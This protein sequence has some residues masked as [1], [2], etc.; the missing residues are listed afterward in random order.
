M[1]GKSCVHCVVLS[2]RGWSIPMMFHSGWNSGGVVEVSICDT[3]MVCVCMQL[4]VFPFVLGLRLCIAYCVCVYQ[5]VIH[6]SLS[7]AELTRRTGATAPGYI[8]P[9]RGKEGT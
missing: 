9:M 3:F 1:S 8:E 2:E 5:P 6:V 4:G 7:K